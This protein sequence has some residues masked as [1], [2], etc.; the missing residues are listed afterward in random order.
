MTWNGLQGFQTPI[1][2]DSFIVDGMG[3]FGTMHQERG[4]TCKPGSPSCSHSVTHY[5]HDSRR[6]LVQWT[7]DTAYAVQHM[8]I[9]MY[10]HLFFPCRICPLGSVPDYRVPFRKTSLPVRIFLNRYHGPRSPGA[11]AI[12][13]V[14]SDC[15]CFTR[16]L[17]CADGLVISPYC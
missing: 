15:T 6:V 2:P 7:Y 9:L 13:L 1:E 5:T 8:C 17:C 12:L 14:Y 4:L 10:S 16:M 3:N 11:V